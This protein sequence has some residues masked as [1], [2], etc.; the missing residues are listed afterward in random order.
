M[1][2]QLVKIEGEGEILIP[3]R[4]S[5]GGEEYE[6]VSIG[7]I[8]DGIFRIDSIADP[9]LEI[10]R[11]IVPKTVKYIFSGAF[12]LAYLE[13]IDVADG[14]GYYIDIDGILYLADDRSVPEWRPNN[15]QN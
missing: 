1:Q 6:V 12:N 5:F 3:E 7:K 2:V 4:V 15:Y 14:N 10:T 13:Y 9:Y 8:V 11:I